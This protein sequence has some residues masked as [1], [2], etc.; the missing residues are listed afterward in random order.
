MTITFVSSAEQ[1]TWLRLLE[2]DGERC[3]QR[4]QRRRARAART[5]PTAD[6]RPQR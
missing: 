1:R 5:K 3:W 4:A 6:A 2:L